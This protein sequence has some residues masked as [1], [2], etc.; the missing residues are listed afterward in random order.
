MIPPNISFLLNNP[1]NPLKKKIVQGGKAVIFGLKT[2]EDDHANINNSTNI[3]S[4]NENN[5]DKENSNNGLNTNNI[6]F[7]NTAS[8]AIFTKIPMSLHKSVIFNSTPIGHPMPTNLFK[9]V[10]VNANEQNK[11]INSAN[12]P[13]VT[14][15]SSL[16][17]NN[18]GFT[19][20]QEKSSITNEKHKNLSSAANS[21]THGKD[22][23]N[24]QN[25]SDS[26]KFFF[27]VK[28]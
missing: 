19:N 13:N 18:M 23:S 14:G 21:A 10:Q 25:S 22:V 20:A 11:I 6:P 17:S 24:L 5:I 26:K 12:N 4:N 15:N 8:R 3:S 2:K 16:N 9:S 28:K 1:N 7:G 27:M